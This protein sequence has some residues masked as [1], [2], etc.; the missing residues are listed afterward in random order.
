MGYNDG[1][2]HLSATDGILLEIPEAKLSP[3]DLTYIQSQDVYKKAQKVTSYLFY[4][5]GY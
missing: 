1:I 2:V 4:S 5:S 3:N